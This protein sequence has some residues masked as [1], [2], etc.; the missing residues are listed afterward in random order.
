MRPSFAAGV[1]N[2]VPFND[3]AAFVFEQGKVKVAGKSLFELLHKLFGIVVAVYTYREYLNPILF[4]WGEQAFQLAELLCAVGSPL[5]AI[6]YQDI[7]LATV[8]LR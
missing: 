5:A 1:V 3:L 6:K 8:D 7:L 4:I 2:T